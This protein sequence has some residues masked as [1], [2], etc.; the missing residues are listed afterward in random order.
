MSARDSLEFHIALEDYKAEIVNAGQYKTV[1]EAFE[2][3]KQAARA[4]KSSRIDVV[5]WTR[6]AARAWGGDFAV[7]MYNEDPDASVHERL[8][9]DD[10]GEWCSTGRVA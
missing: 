6:A 1:L 7:E 8:L 9:L 4:A 10:D 3:A 5:T 2:A